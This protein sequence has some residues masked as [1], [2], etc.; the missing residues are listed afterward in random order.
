MDPIFAT[1]CIARA[2][3]LTL[4]YDSRVPPYR[5]TET[6]RKFG[7]EEVRER[8]LDVE[9]RLISSAGSLII[10]LNSLSPRVRRRLSLAHEIGHLILNECADRAPSCSDHSDVL[11]ERLCNNIA[12]ELLVPQWALVEYLNA[13]PFFDGWVKGITS[14][15]VLHAAAAFDVSVDVMTKRVFHDLKLAPDKIAVIWRHSL[16]KQQA[17]SK[18][19]L[20]VSSAWHSL[21]DSLFVPL[22]KTAVPGSLICRAFDTGHRCHG[23]ECVDLGS[24]RRDFMVDAIAFGSFA[25]GARS[26]PSRAVLSL[27][28]PVD[29]KNRPATR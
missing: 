4:S 6:L 15:V 19:D 21:G 29:E 17:S 9:A 24:V 12:G 20:R 2:R 11:S 8:L 3:E 5:L 28:T 16:H 7:V 14:A 27:L 22:N 23:R 1:K 25:T 13:A 26:K 18:R 10:E